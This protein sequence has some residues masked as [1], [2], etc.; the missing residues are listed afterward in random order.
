M[1]RSH[2]E[3][4]SGWD[5]GSVTVELAVLGPALLL[6]VFAVVQG[7]LVFHARSL[8]LAAATEGVTA[9]RAHGATQDAGTQRARSFL[10]RTAGDTLTDLHLSTAGSGPTRVRVQVT[11]RVISILPGVPGLRVSQAAQAERERFTTAGSLP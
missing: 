9:A 6:A 10:D 3:R 7:G 1:G 8:A 2:A 5:R 4:T 11:G